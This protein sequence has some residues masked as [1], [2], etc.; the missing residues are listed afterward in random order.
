M[1]LDFLNYWL[2]DLLLSFPLS[3]DQDITTDIL[4]DITTDNATDITTDTNLS[5]AQ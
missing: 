3:G 4:N 1:L 5:R 2:T